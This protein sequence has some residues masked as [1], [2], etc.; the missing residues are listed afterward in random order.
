MNEWGS[1]RVEK[2]K[3]MMMLFILKLHVKTDEKK[4][5]SLSSYVTA[6]KPFLI[7]TK[8]TNCHVG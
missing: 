7:C 4:T 1:G 8:I 6:S 2:L 5:I 3:K